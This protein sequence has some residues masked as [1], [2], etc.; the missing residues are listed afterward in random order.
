MKIKNKTRLSIIVSLCLIIVISLT[1][2]IIS[3]Q[4]KR[5]NIKRDVT[6]N[7]VVGVFELNMLTLDYLT[8]RIGRA[9]IQWQNRHESIARLLVS[10]VFN[11]EEELIIVKNIHAHHEKLRSDFSALVRNYR[12]KSLITKDIQIRDK[13]DKRLVTLLSIE[14]QS[15]I[16]ETLELVKLISLKFENKQ[17]M[18]T[19]SIAVSITILILVIGSFAYIIIHDVIRP[20]TKLQNG[21]EFVGKGHLDHNIDITSND[22]I[23]D[24]TGAFN[25]MTRKLEKYYLFL[26]EK[27]KE[28]TRE[29]NVANE[30]VVHGE[31]LSAIG[32]LSASI[33]HE[34]NNPIFGIRNALEIVAENDLDEDTS[35]IVRIAI[36]ECNRMAGLIRNLQDF[37]RPSSGVL[38][39]VNIHAIIDDMLILTKKKLKERGITVEKHYADSLPLINAV[40]DQVAQVFLN[41]IQNADDSIVDGNGKITITTD[42][43]NSKVLVHIK[44]TGGGI[45]QQ[46]MSTIFE[47]FFTT[48]PA[49]KGTGLGLSVC[50][51]IV[52]KFGGDIKVDSQ[53][54]KETTFTVT[55]PFVS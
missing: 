45:P 20:M 17:K 40:H 14:S 3:R 23:A 49:L 48:K 28:R 16:S 22:E 52:K 42:C 26:E 39:L 11:E 51:G 47:P 2:L 54:G 25:D 41:L 19:I 46:S 10:E 21:T 43:D 1:L 33:A 5:L 44:D 27:V 18:A 7:I 50:H 36:K 34:F 24:L 32:K 6:S 9:R 38:S 4:I 55:L 29:L 31:K 35:D 12:K 37:N 30:K 13:L 8:N 53:V 15:I